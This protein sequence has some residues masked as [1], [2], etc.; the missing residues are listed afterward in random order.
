MS[1]KLI[2]NQP[3]SVS[4]IISEAKKNNISI[5]ER[6]DGTSKSTWLNAEEDEH[7][8]IICKNCKHDKFN[9]VIQVPILNDNNKLGYKSQYQCINCGDFIMNISEFKY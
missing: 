9:L 2:K 3:K 8:N 5:L 6:E 1:N 4:Q 7:E